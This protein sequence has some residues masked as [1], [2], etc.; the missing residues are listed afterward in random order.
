MEHPRVPR[1]VVG[2]EWVRTRRHAARMRTRA[3]LWVCA[4]ALG[5]P[6][7]PVGL[8]SAHQYAWPPPKGRMSPRA[9][10]GEEEGWFGWQG[11]GQAG[12]REG[13]GAPSALPR[14]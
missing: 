3:R 9:G 6:S 10:G 7:D 11:P 1:G 13:V 12:A 5:N 14:R 2:W 4:R 8:T